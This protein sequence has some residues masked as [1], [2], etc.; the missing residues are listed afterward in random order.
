MLERMR[1][2]QLT[3]RSQEV[4]LGP[5][6]VREDVWRL[7]KWVIKHALANAYRGSLWP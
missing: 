2:Q 7:K 4:R 5:I 3:D 6:G 1:I